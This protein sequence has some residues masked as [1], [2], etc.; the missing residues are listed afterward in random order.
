MFSQPHYTSGLNWIGHIP[1][2]FW[3]MEALMPKVFVEI[4]AGKGESFFAFCQAADTLRIAA[5]AF[6]VVDRAEAYDASGAEFD[7]ILEYN[8]STYSA[9]SQVVQGS[10]RRVVQNF[11]DGTVDLLH[12]RGDVDPENVDRAFEDWLPKLSERAVVIL[13]DTNTCEK[14]IGT[15]KLFENLQS[16]YPTFE[17]VHDL[18][19]GVIGVGHAQNDKLEHLFSCNHSNV[20]AR[21]ARDLFFALSRACSD[22]LQATHYRDMVN[23]LRSDL[24]AQQAAVNESKVSIGAL[25]SEVKKL[26]EEKM[27]LQIAKGKLEK[28]LQSRFH[29]IVKL[30]MLVEETNS[31]LVS[32][33][34]KLN[35]IKSAR[36]KDVKDPVGMPDPAKNT[37]SV[38][39]RL[40][41]RQSAVERQNAALSLA[42]EEERQQVRS[43]AKL[44]LASRVGNVRLKEKA[45]TS[46]VTSLL[47]P[48]ARKGRARRLKEEARLLR[49]S[50][51][52]D[53]AWYLEKYPDVQKAGFDPVEHYLRFGAA[54]NRD[55][56]PLFSTR[57]YCSDYPD[58]AEAKMNPLLHYIKHGIEESRIIRSAKEFS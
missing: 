43:L 30:T 18:G 12:I 10:S 44:L 21:S 34:H 37:A 40:Q 4:G 55:P 58:V 17:F 39:N 22:K 26:S 11:G 49:L 48:Y 36:V 13:S 15:P 32:Y 42:L 56:S 1:F 47:A 33:E 53:E 7:D 14:S 51:F 25:E 50:G 5:K 20:V 19:L 52:F 29:E 31:T 9:F 28:S 41:E 35:S 24:T 16:Q 54:E 8:N 2:A 23:H 6:L 57:G 27:Q 38:E 3:V 46:L 45:G